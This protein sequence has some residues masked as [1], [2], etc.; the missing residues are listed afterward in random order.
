[1]NKNSEQFKHV[2]LTL[3]FEGSALNR[4]EKV[5]GNILSIKKLKYGNKIVSFIG[6]PAIRHYLFETLVKA[7]GWKPSLVTG[8][9]EVVQFDITKDDILSSPELDAFGYM[10]TIGQQASITRKSPVGITKAIGLDPYEGDMA[11]YANHDLVNRGIK[12]G[13]NV[14]PNP[15]SKEEHQS[16]YKVSFTIDVDVLG[17]DEWIVSKKSEFNNGELRISL[18]DKSDNKK[19]DNIIKVIKNVEKEGDKYKVENGTIEW[20]EIEGK[21]KIIFEVSKEEKKKRI[22][23][24][25]N[26][27]K[28]G[29]YAQSSNE[30]NT[31]IPLFLIA[32]YVK[33]P[34]PIFHPYLDLVQISEKTYQVVGVN[35]ALQN[36]WIDGDVFLMDSE[37]V[38]VEVDKGKLGKKVT[39][40]WSSFLKVLGI[41]SVV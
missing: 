41:D 31:I 25:I 33:I 16:F 14:T 8:Q 13:L 36:S 2:T 19:E 37:K 24:I 6:K 34:S 9:G 32:G 35:D 40:D 7:Y 3:I 28:N 10:Y 30:Q 18:T 17:R 4:D 21:Y 38:R 12:Q 5:G 23:Q 39:Q 15:Y 22:E 11:F 20:K 1:M 26:A 27:I 29:L